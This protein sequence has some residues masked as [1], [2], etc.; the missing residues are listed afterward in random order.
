MRKLIVAALA[1]SLLAPVGAAS[2]Q[3]AG[4]VRRS[5]REVMRSQQ[6]LREA[7]RYGD[8]DD[9]REARRELREDRRE[10]REDWRDYRERNRD[11]YRA[12]RYYGPRGYRYRPVV[13]GYTF[14]PH[15]Y[16]SRYWIVDP[17]RYRLGPA[18]P[19]QRW[20]RYGNDVVLINIRSGRV[21]RVYRDFFW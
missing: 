4:E 13:V 11:L 5:E 21:L 10:L 20:I 8:R 14:Q 2:A 18:G 17:Y 1:A 3:S 7:R 19:N 6:D 12:G 16:A 15:Y 9:V